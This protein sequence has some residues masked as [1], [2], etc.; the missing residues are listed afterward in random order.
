M[1][2]KIYS[3]EIYTHYNDNMK[4]RQ[5]HNIFVVAVCSLVFKSRARASHHALNEEQHIYEELV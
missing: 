2:I 5:Q 4:I 3:V 1:T